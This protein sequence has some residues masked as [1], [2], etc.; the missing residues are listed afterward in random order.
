MIFLPHFFVII[1]SSCIIF[2]LYYTSFQLLFS[3]LE[4]SQMW[5]PWKAYQF[6]SCNHLT[7]FQWFLNFSLLSGTKTF[8]GSPCTVSASI[9]ELSTSQKIPVLFYWIFRSPVF[10][11][12]PFNSSFS[13]PILRSNLLVGYFIVFT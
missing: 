12:K 6:N 10:L 9:L 3:T 8:L 11:M 4:W 13:N 7:C 1:M 2:Y 5:S